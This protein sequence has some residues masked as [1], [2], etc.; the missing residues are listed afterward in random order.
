M[1]GVA[2]VLQQIDE[3]QK[4]LK[5]A[6]SLFEAMGASSRGCILRLMCERYGVTPYDARR[7]R[8]RAPKGWRVV[9]GGKDAKGPQ[10]GRRAPQGRPQSDT[11]A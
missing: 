1:V 7:R 6:E 4:R 3:H 2:S 9:Q 10:R 11:E 8:R 5:D